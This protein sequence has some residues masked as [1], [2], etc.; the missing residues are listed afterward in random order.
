MTQ[1]QEKVA[2]KIIAYHKQNNGICEW[3]FIY[4]EAG[5]L[6]EAW[7]DHMLA[8][9]IKLIK[10]SLLEHN[11]IRFISDESSALTSNGQIFISFDELRKQLDEEKKLNLLSVE[12]L[13]L[14]VEELRNKYFDYRFTK[15]LAIIGIILAGL[16]ALGSL[17]ALLKQ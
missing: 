2:E 17:L 5:L 11:L 16:S 9:H 4:Y 6:P 3:E 12:K 13:Q 1:E 7:E 10:S 15:R 8:Q 14:E